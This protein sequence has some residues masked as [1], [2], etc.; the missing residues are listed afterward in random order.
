MLATN[1]DINDVSPLV[2]FVADHYVFVTLTAR[3][4]CLGSGPALGGDRKV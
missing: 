2:A 1:G 4:H 3:S